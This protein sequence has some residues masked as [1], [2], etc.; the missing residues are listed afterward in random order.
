MKRKPLIALAASLLLST[1]AFSVIFQDFSSPLKSTNTGADAFL[2]TGGIG[3]NFNTAGAFGTW[4]YAPNGGINDPATGDGTGV[5]VNNKITSIGMA[6]AQAGRGTNARA[7]Y[8]VFAASNFT[9]GT[10][11]TITFDVIGDPVGNQGVGRLWLAEL[12]GYDTSGN[13][14]IQMD[15]THDGWGTSAGSPR[16][17]VAQGTATVN[18]LLGDIANNGETIAGVAASGINSTNS[19]T[20][21]YTTSGADIGFAIGTFNNVFGID[22]LSIIPEPS[23]Y[24]LLAGLLALGVLVVRRRRKAAL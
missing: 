3:F 14:F 16:P 21:T 11:Y 23:S 6:R 10:T 18:Y 24:A 15:G 17:F 12:S 4:I 13:N 5:N 9:V 1:Q 19:Y 20:F 22:N 7:F 8:T 2:G